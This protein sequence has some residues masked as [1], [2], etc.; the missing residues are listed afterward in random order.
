MTRHPIPSIAAAIALTFP[1]AAAAETVYLTAGRMLDPES[2]RITE[3]AA[4]LVED[5]KIVRAGS[6][7]AIT[8]PDGARTV[9]LGDK[10]ILPG[11]IDMHTH[12]TGDPTKGR[13]GV[14]MDAPS[15][16]CSSG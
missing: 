6:A 4:L 9:K 1:A 7:S 10:T 15:R 5:G 2:G 14:T 8:A 16:R 3:D 11:L 13:V 12:L